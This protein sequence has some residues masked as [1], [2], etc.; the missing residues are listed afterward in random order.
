MNIQMLPGDWL[1]LLIMVVILGA[2]TF[3][4]LNAKDDF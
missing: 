4:H 3:G 1:A 2:L